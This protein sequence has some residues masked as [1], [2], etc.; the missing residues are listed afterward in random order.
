MDTKK[1]KPRQE[2]A[3]DKMPEA[4]RYEVQMRAKQSFRN[5]YEII[6]PNKKFNGSEEVSK[7]PKVKE[8]IKLFH[9]YFIRKVCENFNCIY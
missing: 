5:Y 2:I 4:K 1:T 8:E 7:R 9:F 6:I 3:L